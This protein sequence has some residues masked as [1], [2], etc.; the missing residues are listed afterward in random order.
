[1][2]IRA[3]YF[4]MNRLKDALIVV[5]SNNSKVTRKQDVRKQFPDLHRIAAI[6]EEI[7]YI[8][9]EKNNCLVYTT[10]RMEQVF[11]VPLKA[12]L[13]QFEKPPFLQIHRSYC[14][15]PNFL[16]GIV[17]QGRNWKAICEGLIELPISRFHQKL[18][19]KVYRDLK[20]N[21]SKR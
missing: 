3:W 1:M 7:R 6:V 9:V 19:L 18:V 14:I 16:T 8:K 15:N 20:K 13:E 12:I 17:K 11:R 2:G 4:Q 10:N 5:Q 21:I